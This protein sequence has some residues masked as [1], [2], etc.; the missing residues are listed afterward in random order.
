[1]KITPLIIIIIV[2]GLGLAGWNYSANQAAT[3]KMV[4]NAHGGASDAEATGLRKL[5]AELSATQ[6]SVSGERKEAM[7][8]SKGALTMLNRATEERK[9]AQDVLEGRKSEREEWSDKVKDAE[10][11]SSQIQQES[12]ALTAFLRTLPA[13]GPDVDLATAVERL[14]GV[15]K[16]EVEKKKTLTAD[17]DEK[18]VVRKAATDKVAGETAELNRLTEINNQFFRDYQKNGDEFVIQAVDP[19]WKFVVFTVGKDS[20]LTVGDSTA[21]LVKR[22]SQPL[23]SLRIVSISGGMVIAEYDADKLP[24][25]VSLEVGDRVF[26]QK[27]L[28]S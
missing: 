25:G 8:T 2:L 5:N 19:R 14:D 15:V 7:N 18:V 3:M 16:E 17:Y 28:G 4:V 26:R 11:R 9:S 27:P 22:G 13:L 12:D 24:A 21:L 6:A 1:M 10:A 20:G 23:G